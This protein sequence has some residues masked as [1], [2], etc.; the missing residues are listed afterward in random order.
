MVRHLLKGFLVLGCLG[1]AACKGGS[2][3]PTS[4]AADTAGETKAPEAAAAPAPAPAN[5]SETSSEPDALPHEMI[6]VIA[7]GA[8]DKAPHDDRGFSDPA[9]VPDSGPGAV[10]PASGEGTPE[11]TTEDA[12]KGDLP[13]AAAIAIPS[14]PA[15]AGDR[16]T[17]TISGPPAGFSA[18]F[19]PPPPHVERAP[20]ARA[21]RTE[22]SNFF[23]LDAGGGLRGP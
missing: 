8:G 15:D 3:A 12:P 21:D 11:S 10:P 14:N 20:F 7:G 19:Q 2:G 17:W 1:L 23:V 6:R 22:T 4:D 18:D 5:D 16:V 13:V 9:I